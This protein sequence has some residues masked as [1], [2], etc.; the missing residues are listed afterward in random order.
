[1]ILE[2]CEVEISPLHC[3]IVAVMNLKHD[4]SGLRSDELV[5]NLDHRLAVEPSLYF[6]ALY[7]ETESI[8]LALLE[9]VFLFVWDL[10][11]PSTS[12]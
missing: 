6:V 4:T 5:I 1:M 12:V 8:P 9:D 3:N 10:N 11:K 2:G 7:A